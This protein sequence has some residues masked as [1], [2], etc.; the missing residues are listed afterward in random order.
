[1]LDQSAAPLLDSSVFRSKVALGKKRSIK[2][3]IPSRA[4]RQTAALPALT[5][6]T[7][8]DWRFCDSTGGVN[9]SHHITVQSTSEYSVL[10]DPL[11]SVNTHLWLVEQHQSFTDVKDQCFNGADSESEEEPSRD[12]TSSPAPSQP[13]R[14]PMFPGMDPS[15]LMVCPC[16]CMSSFGCL[17]N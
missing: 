9:T 16:W 3:T 11:K 1:M 6:G 14:V 8:P 12:V 5:E 2:R 4:V 15:A 17:T 10:H 13:K 7:Q